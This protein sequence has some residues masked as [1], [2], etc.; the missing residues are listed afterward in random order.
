MSELDP[1]VVPG[2]AP[3]RLHWHRRVFSSVAAVCVAF[4][5]LTTVA[6]M[7]YPGG[8]FPI[9]GTHGYQFFVNYFSDLGQTHTQSGAANFASMMLFTTAML[10]VGVGVGA[11]FLAYARFF[12]T[13]TTDTKA[14]RLSRV[15]TKFGLAS[16]ACY[17]GLGLVPENIFAAGH[18]LFAQ[19]AFDFLLVALV[20]EIFALRRTSGLSPWL[21]VVNSVFVVVLFGYV[22]LTILGPSS[23]TL[24]GDEINVVG[25][26]VIVYV[27]IATIFAQALLVRAHL[28][29]PAPAWARARSRAR[30]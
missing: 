13:K 30:P 6:M 2:H 9:V 16:A 15:A 12:R 17:I 11:F 26:K 4:V 22:L 27:A 5:A 28:P 1:I 8:S 10:A 24:I 20:L 29:R 25:Q 18:F 21:L 23:H 14:L 19:G 7:V 3:A